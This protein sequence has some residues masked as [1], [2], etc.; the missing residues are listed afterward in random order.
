MYIDS[1]INCNLCPSH[2][3]RKFVEASK[4]KSGRK[5]KELYHQYLEAGEDWMSS[6]LVISSVQSNTNTTGGKTGWLSRKEPR[7]G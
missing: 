1:K 3:R 4:D 6:T 7:L 2:S 5:M